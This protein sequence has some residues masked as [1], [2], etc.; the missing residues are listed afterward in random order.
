MSSQDFLRKPE[1]ILNILL[2]SFTLIRFLQIKGPIC[3]RSGRV[4]MR[5]PAQVL[6]GEFQNVAL[7]E[8]HRKDPSVS[9]GG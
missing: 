8:L 2:I 3:G 7:W 6:A 9:T 5:I 1:L 4:N